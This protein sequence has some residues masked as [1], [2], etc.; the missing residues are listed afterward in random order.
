KPFVKPVVCLIGFRC[1]SSGEGFAQMMKCLPQV[2][3][4][5]VR[6]RG[7]SGN[8]RPFKL[9]G[10]EVTVSYSRWV[11]M[12]PDGSPIEGAGIAPDIECDFPAEAYKDKDPTWEKALQLLREKIAKAG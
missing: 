7:S 10:V 2:T 12:M 5:G 9:P 11:D 6:T 1:V 8:P 4:V 3:T